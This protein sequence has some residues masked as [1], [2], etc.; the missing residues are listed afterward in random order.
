MTSQTT[1]IEA[2]KKMA[3]WSVT[4]VADRWQLAGLRDS[5]NV[6]V[7]RKT[8]NSTTTV[9]SRLTTGGVV[10][11]SRADLRRFLPDVNLRLVDNTHVPLGHFLV[12]PSSFI[13]Q[14]VPKSAADYFYF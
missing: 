3:A 10:E 5:L 1:C 14:N 9:T 8:R 6:P 13:Q 12:A 2:N 4:T 7:N 11:R